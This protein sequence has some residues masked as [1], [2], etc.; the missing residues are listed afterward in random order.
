[1]K[2]II[3]G[4]GKV[5]SQLAKSLSAENHDITIIDQKEN[6]RQDLDNNL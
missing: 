1:M 2:I 6:I 3:I 5:G 4:A